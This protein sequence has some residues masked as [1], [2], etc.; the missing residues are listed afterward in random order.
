MEV[1]LHEIEVSEY[2]FFYTLYHRFTRRG[3]QNLGNLRMGS[4][5]LTRCI[6]GRGI[7]IRSGRS[8]ESENFLKRDQVI[9]V[10]DAIFLP[11]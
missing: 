2:S 1:D 8:K 9:K 5:Y 4:K 10:N 6:N 7:R 11:N 3:R